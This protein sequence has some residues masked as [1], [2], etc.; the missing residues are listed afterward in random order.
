MTRFNQVNTSGEGSRPTTAGGVDNIGAGKSAAPG[1]SAAHG[2]V[3]APPAK[4]RMADKRASAEN[5]RHDDLDVFGIREDLTPVPNT[6]P[7]PEPKDM[8]A[9]SPKGS[10]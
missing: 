2:E 5:S 8:P 4:E 9:N 10:A 3:N 7:V 6:E 1:K